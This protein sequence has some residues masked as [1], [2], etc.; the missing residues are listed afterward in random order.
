MSEQHEYA[1]YPDTPLTRM[2]RL[3]KAPTSLDRALSALKAKGHKVVDFERVRGQWV[4]KL[5]RK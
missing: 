2:Q 1:T 4:F 3:A 5:E